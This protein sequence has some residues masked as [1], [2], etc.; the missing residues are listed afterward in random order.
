MGYSEGSRTPTS[1]ELGCA[2]PNFG[3]RLPNSMAGDPALKQVVS[4]SWE[5]GLRGK[6]SPQTQWNLGVFRG[7][8]TD[9]ILFVAN[10]AAT[11]FFKNFGKTRRQ[12]LELGLSSSVERLR[13]RFDYTYLQASYQSQD[14]LNG[15]FN[16]GAD[17]DG[18]IGVQPGDRMPL[19]PQQIFKARADYQFL[20]HLSIGLNMIAIGSSF[21]RGNENNSHE[22]DGF[23]S[24]GSGSVP[25][26]AVFGL[27]ANYKPG[28]QLKL[29]ANI[30]NL[31]NREYMSAGQLRPFAI[32]PTG[33]YSNSDTLSTTFYAPGAP[34]SLSIGARYEF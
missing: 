33:G 20:P 28:K 30:S 3:C 17:A 19:I 5:A 34:R 7:D 14:S 29:F 16:S 23:S 25:G 13:V 22:P 9:E 6:L 10:S 2:D 31:F 8:N 12:G 24:F 21:V 1:I 15:E 32:T 27:S 18:F 11:G 4:K 26:Y